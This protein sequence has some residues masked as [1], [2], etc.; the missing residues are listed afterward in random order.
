MTIYDNLKNEKQ[1][2]AST[3]LP[4]EKFDHLFSH[5]EKL[6]S[7][8]ISNPYLPDKQPVL[9]NKREALFFI[10]HYLKSYP[11]L[12]NMGMYF[13]FSES[14]ASNAI[15]RIMPVLK[16]AFSQS[17]QAIR[18]EFCDEKTFAK[19]FENVEDIFIDGFEIPTQRPDNE[20]IQKSTYS[21]K[22][23]FTP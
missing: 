21:G 10:L 17:G 2:K 14:A 7:S 19:L 11:T 9:T 16:L 15:E 4:K 22:K 8:K 5:F 18:R 23:N 20:A 1:Y 12:V 6:Y 3:G 13:G